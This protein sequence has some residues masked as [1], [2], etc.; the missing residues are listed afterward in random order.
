MDLAE[1]KYHHHVAQAS[2]IQPS[3]GALCA[4]KHAIERLG[5]HF[6]IV[7]DVPELDSRGQRGYQFCLAYKRVPKNGRDR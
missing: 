3:S 2:W 1:I 7:R 6:E 4:K 5:R